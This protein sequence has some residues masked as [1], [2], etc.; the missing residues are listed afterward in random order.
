MGVPI[1]THIPLK[2]V[3]KQTLIA[4]ESKE[5]SYKKLQSIEFLKS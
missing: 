4:P 3:S 2:Q 5:T 1:S